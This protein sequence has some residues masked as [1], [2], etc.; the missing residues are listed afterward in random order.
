MRKF[1]GSLGVGTEKRANA[2][3]SDSRLMTNRQ[4]THLTFHLHLMKPKSWITGQSGTNPK[5]R[6]ADKSPR[7]SSKADRYSEKQ[8]TPT[9]Q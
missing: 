2:V 5:V 1:L 4:S 8:K 7:M 6:V 3:R 9:V